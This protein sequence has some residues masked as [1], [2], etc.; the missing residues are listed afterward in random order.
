MKNDRFHRTYRPRLTSEKNINQEDKP[1]CTEF[2]G[3]LRS[4]KYFLYLSSREL[5]PQVPTLCLQ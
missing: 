4:S 1:L 2:Q 3:F 5:G